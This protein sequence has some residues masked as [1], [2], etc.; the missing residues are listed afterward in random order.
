[1]LGRLRLP[2]SRIGEETTM[3]VNVGEVVSTV[4]PEPEQSGSATGSAESGQEWQRSA[5]MRDM[6]AQIHRDRRR[7]TAEHFDD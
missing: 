1:M 7:T 4:T 6:L 5:A 3:P 2:E